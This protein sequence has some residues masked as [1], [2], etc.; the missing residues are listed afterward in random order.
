MWV[1]V[2][3][4][5]LRKLLTVTLPTYTIGSKYEITRGWLHSNTI[6]HIKQLLK[7]SQKYWKEISTTGFSDRA[8]DDSVDSTTSNRQTSLSCA[9]SN[10][11]E[12]DVVCVRSGVTIHQLADSIVEFTDRLIVAIKI[13]FWFNLKQWLNEI[14][15]DRTII[16]SRVVD[17]VRRNTQ[18]ASEPSAM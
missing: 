8:V 6:T 13:G 5:Q 4:W 15:K 14:V 10:S 18:A 12:V 9:N 11:Y 1:P 7:R 3:V 2:A 16:T 17:P